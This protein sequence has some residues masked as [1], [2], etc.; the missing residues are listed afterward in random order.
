VP[1]SRPIRTAL[2]LVWERGDTWVIRPATRYVWVVFLGIVTLFAALIGFWQWPDLLGAL[3]F[4]IPA[5][6]LAARTPGGPSWSVDWRRRD[7]GSGNLRS[8]FSEIRGLAPETSSRTSGNR[9]HASTS[10]VW[11]LRLLGTNLFDGSTL[12][13]SIRNVGMFRAARRLAAAIGV[14]LYDSTGPNNLVRGWHPE[15]GAAPLTESIAISRDSGA[16]IPDP[17]SPPEA[18]EEPRTDGVELFWNVRWPWPWEGLLI[19]FALTLLSL[20]LM[21]YVHSEWMILGAYVAWP[22]LLISL[23]LPRDHGRNFVRISS[24]YVTLGRPFPLRHTF[25]VRRARVAEVRVVE[26]VKFPSWNAQPKP[27]RDEI[28]LL[29][30]NAR[31]LRRFE[32]PSGTGLWLALAIE[33]ALK[34]L[35]ERP[36]SPWVEAR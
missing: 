9:S 17:R 25:R 12:A 16:K 31:L 15:V 36:G 34:P 8:P 10:Q 35:P 14:P 6:L 1:A 3:G 28:Q 22:M 2:S 24:E 20:Y 27:H 30:D 23:F 19:S 13:W 26:L 11:Q 33:R 4:I 7:L 32:V 18:G 21:V 29:G 5:M